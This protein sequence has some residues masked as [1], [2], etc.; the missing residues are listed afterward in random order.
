MQESGVGDVD[1]LVDQLLRDKD[2]LLAQ[3]LKHK[4]EELNQLFVQAQHQELK[5]ELSVSQLDTPSGASVTW[6]EIKIFKEI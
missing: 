1:K 2:F 5:V 4:V 6:L 3:E